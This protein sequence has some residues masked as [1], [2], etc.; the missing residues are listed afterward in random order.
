MKKANSYEPC[1]AYSLALRITNAAGDGFIFYPASRM[2]S[3]ACRSVRA[4][5][6]REASEEY[7]YF[8]LLEKLYAAAGIPR[9]TC[10]PRCSIRCVRAS[11]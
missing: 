3:T 4:H 11:T 10:L 7:E 6:Y 2:K 9:K 5:Q 1:D 8:Y